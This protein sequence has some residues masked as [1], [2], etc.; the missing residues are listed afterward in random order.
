MNECSVS[1][2]SSTVV[3]TVY[4]VLVT[5]HVGPAYT[6]HMVQSLF[7]GSHVYCS[8]FI[9][10]ADL[11]LLLFE[12]AQRRAPPKKESP[13][14]QSSGHCSK[15]SSHDFD[16]IHVSLSHCSKGLTYTTYFVLFCFFFCSAFFNASLN[17]RNHT[18]PPVLST[19]KIRR[20]RHD[21]MAP[22]NNKRKRK[23]KDE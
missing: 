19:R 18:A 5:V 4:A 20:D 9:F 17:R 6:V 12:P 3:C 13:A 7:S 8:F 11:F 10:F 1:Q 23:E 14:S 22:E 16:T 21:H 2:P 15:H